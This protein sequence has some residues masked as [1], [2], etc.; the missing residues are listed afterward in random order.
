MG[1]LAAIA[2][3]VAGLVC[4]GAII[5]LLGLQDSEAVGLIGLVLWIACSFGIA[6][7]VDRIRRTK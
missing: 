1:T 3:T 6:L 4:A 2:I 5:M 7:I